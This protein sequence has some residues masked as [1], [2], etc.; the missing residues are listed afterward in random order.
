MKLSLS[1]FAW[2]F[3]D[4]D[5]IGDFLRKKN[6]KNVELIFTKYKDWS[7]INETELLNLKILLEKYD[8]SCPSSQSLFYNVDCNSIITESDKFIKHVEK[9]I[10]YSKILGIKILVFGSPGLRKI[11]NGNFSN[12]H[13][14]FYKIDNIL[15]GTDIKFCIEPNSKIYGGDFFFTVEEIVNFLTEFKFKNIFTMCD[16]HNSW[17]EGTDPIKEVIKFAPF[18]KHIHISEE[19]LKVIQNFD[20]HLR[21]KNIL[22]N[23]GY[24]KLITYEVLPDIELKSSIDE[25]IKIYKD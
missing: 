5:I 2:N 16:T 6:I 14:T 21:F 24:S 12:L 11:N 18:I 1:N 15:E 7:E 19:K 10:G 9:L 20:F 17:L 8:L 22:E 23:I 25:L 4:I 3:E 13:K